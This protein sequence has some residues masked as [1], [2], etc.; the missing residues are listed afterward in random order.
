MLYFAYGSNMNKKQMKE[1]CPSSKF[2]KR[3]YVEGYEFVYDGYSQSRKGAVANI[4]KSENE[5]VWGCLFEINEDNLS[6]LDCY[7]GYFSR[8]YD[9][10]TIMVKDDEGKSHS[11][12]VYF[13]TG[14]EV[15][16]P[17]EDYQ[18]DVIQGAKDCGLPEDYIKNVLNAK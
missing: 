18:C 9:K 8:V 1:R 7:E 17:H 3:A 2:I 12:I 13:R 5:K 14:K 16:V 15:G 10:K 4:I 6:A 11:V